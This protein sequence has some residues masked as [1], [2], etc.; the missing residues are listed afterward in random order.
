MN[1][2][3]T[4]YAN[5]GRISQRRR[6]SS[7]TFHSDSLPWPATGRPRDGEKRKFSRLVIF[8]ANA[9]QLSRSN[10]IIAGCV[11]IELKTVP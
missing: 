5:A 7:I 6:W 9:N 10:P 11:R 3:P 2:T 4:F 8:N 1:S